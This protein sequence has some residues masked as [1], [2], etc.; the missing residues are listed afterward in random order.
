MT[1]DTVCFICFFQDASSGQLS[2][3]SQVFVHKSDPFVWACHH[4]HPQQQQNLSIF[5]MGP[6]SSVKGQQC[7]LIAAMVFEGLNFVSMTHA[8]GYVLC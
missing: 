4:P 7:G 1:A 6:E 3:G 2:N 5:S 8:M